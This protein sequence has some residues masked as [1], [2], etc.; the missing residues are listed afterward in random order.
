MIE[1]RLYWKHGG[2][3]VDLGSGFYL[4]LPPPGTLLTHPSEH[5]GTWRVLFPYIHLAQYGS[6]AHR[7]WERGERAEPERVYVFVE[8][9]DGPF[10]A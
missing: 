5:G 7:S 2:Q 1:L 6:M 10:E 9:A 4:H 3:D 8:L